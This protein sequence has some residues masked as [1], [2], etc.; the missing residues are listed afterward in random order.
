MVV[1]F[2]APAPATVPLKLDTSKLEQDDVPPIVNVPLPEFS[3]TIASSEEVGIPAIPPV[4]PG[5]K[6]Q[7]AVVAQ[8]PL[9]LFA[10]Y[11]YFTAIDYYIIGS[12][13]IIGVIG[14][15]ITGSGVKSS[16]K[17]SCSNT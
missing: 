2:N 17:P 9:P 3:S 4:P 6:Y 5:P 11:Q 7:F 13:S 12:S 1:I 14:F 8:V 15:S 16:T 10:T